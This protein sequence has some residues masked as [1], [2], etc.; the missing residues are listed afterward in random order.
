[1]GSNFNQ[2]HELNSQGDLEANQDATSTAYY[3][4]ILCHSIATNEDMQF[5]KFVKKFKLRVIEDRQDFE[6]R[7]V[8]EIFQ[9]KDFKEVIELVKY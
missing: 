6:A 3:V 9:N 7:E 5:M 2:K 1:M 8:L 4:M